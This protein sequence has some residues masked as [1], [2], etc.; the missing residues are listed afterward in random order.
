MNYHRE[1]DRLEQICRIELLKRWPNSRIIETKTDSI[2]GIDFAVEIIGRGIAI[3]EVKS[4]TGS[5]KGRQMSI[6][7]IKERLTNNLKE[8]LREG[9][10]KK[11]WLIYSTYRVNER[12][13]D[14]LVVRSAK[15]TGKIDWDDILED[16]FPVEQNFKSII[17]QI[18]EIESNFS[19]KLI[20]IFIE[21]KIDL[22]KIKSD[23]INISKRTNELVLNKKRRNIIREKL[24][25]VFEKLE[26]SLNREKESNLKKKMDI[27]SRLE[28]ISTS[29]WKSAGEK[30]KELQSIWKSIGSVPKEKSDEV[31]KRYKNALDRFYRKRQEHFD[32]KQK[33]WEERQRQKEIRQREWEERQRQR[34]K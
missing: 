2:H 14:G 31:Y 3:V 12:A 17:S 32:R 27:C 1:G 24:N 9:Y 6:D 5:V 7:W 15:P 23:L 30:V 8:K 21:R 25:F 11:Y 26:D 34:R 13:R 19:G 18:N 4:R 33:E 22:K 10:K 29:D 16:I 28:N 20:D